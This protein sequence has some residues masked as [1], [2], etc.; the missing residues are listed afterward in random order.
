MLW[1]CISLPQLPLEALQLGASDAITVVTD[2][3]ANTR[4]IVCCNEAAERGKLKVGMNYTT[5]LAIH[6]SIA[7][8]ERKRHAE[9]AALERLAAWAY[10]FS[11]TVVIGEAPVEIKQARIAAIWLEIGASLKLFGGFRALIEK[12]ENAFAHLRYSYQLG[13]APTLEG[14]ALLARTNIRLALTTRPALQLKISRLP[15]MKL[16]LAT[17]ITEQLYMVGIRTIGALL[18]L[19]RD[20]V[21]RRFGPHTSNYLDRLIGLAPDPRPS[22]QL[23]Y[24]YDTKFEFGFEIGSTEALL[25][26]LRRMLHEFSGFL[27]ARDTAVQRFRLIFLHR[28]RQPTELSIGM[29]IP[30]RNSDKFFALAKEQLERVTL[31]AATIELSLHASEFAAPTGLQNDML[32][33]SVVQTE[34]LSHTIDRIAARLGEDRIHTVMMTPDHRPESSW[35]SA[36]YGERAPALKSPARPLWLLSEPKPL[37]KCG[38]P[39]DGR[40]E[41]IESGWWDDKDVQRDYYLVRTN[42]GAQLWVF[43]DLQSSSWYLHG[44][45]S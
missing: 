2:C 36:A 24:R 19:P 32:S 7:M 18:E 40:P 41:R 14:A 16:A 37:E 44:V 33:G 1:L 27:I 29:S 22:Y 5:A 25:F 35:K 28:E 30:E 4:Y 15:V 34:E 17:Q 3:E 9:T 42:E 8:L 6:S 13:I 26:P 39:T 38:I 20:A 43:K 45:W 23:P 12:F 31:P 10:Q 21:A 11:S